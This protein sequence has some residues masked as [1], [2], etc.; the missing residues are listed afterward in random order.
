MLKTYTGGCHCGAVRFE[1]D[2]D[3][4]AGSGRCNCSYCTKARAWSVQVKPDAFRQT[5]GQDAM[6]DY[7][8]GTKQ[9]HHRFC[10]TCGIAAFGDGHVEQIGGDFVS[11]AVNC[12][13]D[14]TPEQLD[15]VPI[16]YMNGRE[17]LWW[18]PPKQT[19]Y[20]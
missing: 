3:L 2:L 13:D 11:I 15:A 14:L 8:F 19:G 16:Q 18:E 5:A 4:E 1:A 7:Q 12:L 9:G 20:L 17:N 6:S 10:R